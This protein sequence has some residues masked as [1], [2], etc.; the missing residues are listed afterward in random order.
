LTEAM[1]RQAASKRTLC[2]SQQLPLSLNDTD[3]AVR[4]AV[5]NNINCYK[6]SAKQIGDPSFEEIK[7]SFSKFRLRLRLL[8]Q[9]TSTIHATSRHNL[10]SRDMNYEHSG[11]QMTLGRFPQCKGRCKHAYPRM[12]RIGSR[13]W[14]LVG[15]PLFGRSADLLSH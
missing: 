2:M 4:F 10:R 9:V 12:E 5:L 1:P 14:L 8:F 7:Q 3:Y 11:S 6:I 13:S 15:C